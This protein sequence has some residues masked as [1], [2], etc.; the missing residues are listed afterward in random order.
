[1]GADLTEIVVQLTGPATTRITHEPSGTVLQS[2]IAPEFGGP[3]GAFSSTD[4]VAAALGSCIATNLGPI[5]E[6]HSIDFDRFQLRVVKHISPQPRRISRL[7]VRIRVTGVIPDD[8]R[9]RFE[10]AAH[11]CTVHRSLHPE[12]EAPIEFSYDD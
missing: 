10:A 8:L 3:G 5:A 7:E 2:A 12:L 6:R 9:R 11:A 4:L 1:V